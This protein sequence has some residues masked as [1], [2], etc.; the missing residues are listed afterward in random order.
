MDRRRFLGALAAG[1]LA[2]PFAACGSGQNDT[3][4]DRE[5]ATGVPTTPDRRLERIGLQLYTVRAEM[6]KGVD[7]TLA[8]VA[9]IGYTEVEFAGYFN[10]TPQEIRAMLDR[11]GL[12]APA[13]HIPFASLGEGWAKVLEDSAVVGHRYIVIPF[14]DEA[15]R[16]EPDAYSRVAE[17]LNRGAEAT[18]A[19]GMRFAY[20]NH[21]F[22]FASGNGPTGFETLVAE[23]SPDVLFELDLFWATVGGQDPVALFQRHPGRF[24]LVHVKDMRQMP[25]REP[26]EPMVPSERAFEQ[27]ADVGQG[28]ID[29]ARIFD[30]SRVGGVEHYFVEHDHPEA[31]FASIQASY[32]YLDAL[33]Y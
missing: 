28:S 25:A 22:E 2:A 7:A 5:P 33:R 24:P 20:H 1:A 32:E 23:C 17:A 16:N 4:G 14:L 19:A 26:S 12:T 31:P 9:A 30:Q 21:Q 29:W 13:A 10:H 15:T 3:A 18:K 6:E 11:N 27:L 8:R